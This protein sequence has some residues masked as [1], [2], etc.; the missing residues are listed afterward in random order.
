M[1][2]YEEDFELISTANRTNRRES[3]LHPVEEKNGGLIDNRQARKR[4]YNVD[5]WYNSE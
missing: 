4:K 3:D 1:Y 2:V 5:K